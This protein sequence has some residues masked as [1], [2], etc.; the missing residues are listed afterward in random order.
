MGA[1][2]TLT[3]AEAAIYGYAFTYFWMLS[4]GHHTGAEY[5]RFGLL[6]GA[7]CVY[8]IGQ[9]TMELAST[10]TVRELGARLAVFGV[11][12]IVVTL[13][14][15]CFALAGRRGRWAPVVY[16]WAAF[17]LVALL[18]GFVVTTRGP[19][20]LVFVQPAFPTLRI[21]P[22]GYA[23]I[24]CGLVV[25]LPPVLALLPRAR[26]DRGVAWVLATLALNVLAAAYDAGVRVG[27]FAG[28]FLKEHT[29][30]LSIV[31]ICYVLLSRFVD[32]SRT[33]ERRKT[34]LSES[35]AELEATHEA[36]VRQEQLAAVGELSAVLAHEVRNPLAI[37][38]NAVSGFRHAALEREDRTVLLDILDEETD[39]LNGIMEDLLAYARPLEPKWQQLDLREVVDSAVA[40]AKHRAGTADTVQVHIDWAE[41]APLESRGD[42]RL[43]ERALR[44]V[45][46]NALQAMSDARG[47]LTIYVSRGTA[48]GATLDATS[49]RTDRVVFTITDSGLG[50]DESTTGK[51][52]HPFFTTRAKGTGLGLAIAQRS[53]EAHGGTLSITSAPGTGT[54][55][56]IALPVDAERRSGPPSL[57]RAARFRASL[58]G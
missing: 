47:T 53:V 38:K 45:V 1:P 42:P 49:P 21:E 55:V 10:P 34:E 52:T 26:Q 54:R 3:V 19:L 11:V 2:T 5:G 31:A 7:L 51:A 20:D 12:A 8:S 29:A 33:L 6:S 37:I 4:I 15:F 46:A 28:P 9:A 18:G 43:V 13:S 40:A 23:V 16:G 39:R 44:E 41:D 25:V 24:A 30:L 56:R 32:T 27:W 14:E 22:F 35:Y 36:L 58:T 57:E 50:M 17:A 48:S